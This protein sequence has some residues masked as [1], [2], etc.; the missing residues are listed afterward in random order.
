MNLIYEKAIENIESEINTFTKATD[1]Y[2]S[3]IKKLEKAKEAM[4]NLLIEDSTGLE[5][6]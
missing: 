1:Y 4:S 3:R 2:K 5:K 6:S